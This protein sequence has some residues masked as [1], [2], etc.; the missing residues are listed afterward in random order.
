M[1]G[2]GTRKDLGNVG[3]GLKVMPRNVVK[4]KEEYNVGNGERNMQH[5]AIE[6]SF[7]RVGHGKELNAR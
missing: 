7:V 3:V 4:R 2:V 1:A 6:K 5:Q